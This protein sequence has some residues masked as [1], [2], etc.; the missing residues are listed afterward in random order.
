MNALKR[1][2]LLWQVLEDLLKRPVKFPVGVS[3]VRGCDNTYIIALNLSVGRNQRIDIIEAYGLGLS[4]MRI[5]FSH[6]QRFLVRDVSY[7]ILSRRSL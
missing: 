6:Q 3:L 1:T 7:R 4:P 2:L 5:E